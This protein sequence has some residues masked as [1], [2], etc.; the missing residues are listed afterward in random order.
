MTSDARFETVD[1]HT[2]G[3]PTRLVAG[4]LDRAAFEG[5][6]V[7]EQRDAFAETHDEVREHLQKAEAKFLNPG[8]ESLP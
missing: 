8:A 5:G 1:T 2:G 4:G 3:E 7:A 6:S